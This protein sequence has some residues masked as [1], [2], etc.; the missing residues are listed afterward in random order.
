[1]FHF[2]VHIIVSKINC[3]LDSVTLLLAFMDSVGLLLQASLAFISA[4]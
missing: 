4:L 3:Y 1:M 2:S